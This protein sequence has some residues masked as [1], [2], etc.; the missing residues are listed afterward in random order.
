MTVGCATKEF[1]KEEIQK[2]EGKVGQQITQQ[3][4]VIG[5]LETQVGQERERIGQAATR[6]DGLG[7]QMR[8]L[9]GTISEV[10]DV[11]TTAKGTAEQA[12]G[13]AVEAKGTADQ[14]LAK[15]QDV[16]VRLTR[17]WSN[18]H[19]RALAETVSV[20]FGF[21]KWG[22]DDRAQT[23]LLDLAKQLKEN[24][25]LVVEL[26]G[27][28]DSTGPRDY[29]IGLSQRRVEAVRRH[30]VEKGV[31]LSRIHAIG[32]GPANSQVENGSADGRAK[33]RRVTVK[34]FTPKE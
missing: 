3:Q 13:A 34:L 6:I 22:L 26:E 28:T 11:A 5:S 29:N 18:R 8:V 16:D 10:K 21:D 32:L 31:D 9:E 7:V 33:S 12:K 4:E 24:S 2:A 20:H 30:L 14:A 23:A 17:L 19:N 1:V 15:A 27:Y 25:A